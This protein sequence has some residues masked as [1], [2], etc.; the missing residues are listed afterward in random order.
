LPAL[1]AA[2]NHP[3]LLPPF[4]LF[5]PAFQTAPP[6]A[7]DLLIDRKSEL[8]VPLAL[9]NVWLAAVTEPIVRSLVDSPLAF[10]SAK[11]FVV[12]AV[13]KIDAALVLLRVLVMLLNVF[14]PVIVNAPAPPWLS[15]QLNVEPAP[16]KVLAAEAI[17]E[18]VPVPVPAVV[19]NPVGSGLTNE[20]TVPRL[21]AKVP[22]LNVRFFVPVAVVNLPPAVKVFPSK[23]NVP[24][25]RMFEL[26]ALT[27]LPNFQPPPTPLKSIIPEKVAPLVV[28][29]FPI[30]VALNMV[31]PEY[32]RV[33]FVAGQNNDPLTV[34]PMLVPA[35]VIA[36]SRPDAVKSLQTL[37]VFAIVTV[38]AVANT[39]EF[40]S[41]NTL[42]DAVGTDAPPAPPDDADQLA[43][44]VLLQVPVP[45]T[46]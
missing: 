5:A 27:A 13:N 6:V 15:V 33:K 37:G 24:F 4:V 3:E 14:E 46:Q 44:L 45:R 28:T 34:N 36:P 39:F 31:V 42:S 17:I 8:T 30:V 10:Q 23:S 29:V 41:K 18:I 35:S 2:N 11:V 20:F 32:V 7:V 9:D 26:R 16:L 43:V 40:A 21:Q 19:V 1:G 38:N 25:V 12:P 22:P